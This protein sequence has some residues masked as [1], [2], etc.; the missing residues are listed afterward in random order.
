MLKNTNCKQLDI[1][2]ETSYHRIPKKH[3]LLKINSAISLQFVEHR[4]TVSEK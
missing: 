1:F 4:G 2:T 3:I